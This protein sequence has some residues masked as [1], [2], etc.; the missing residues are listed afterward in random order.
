MLSA[1]SNNKKILLAFSLV[2]G[3]LSM[4]GCKKGP[5]HV[6]ASITQPVI[7]AG[8]NNCEVNTAGRV[9][10]WSDNDNGAQ[11]RK[12]GQGTM[13]IIHSVDQSVAKPMTNAIAVDIATQRGC[14]LRSIASSNTR[15][16]E[17]WNTN[18]TPPYVAQPITDW[19]RA[20]NSNAAVN[21]IAV[22]DSQDCALLKNGKV[23]CR[24]N[25]NPMNTPVSVYDSNYEEITT[26]V[27][28]SAGGSHTCALLK[29]GTV[30]CWGANN[31]GQL[32]DG[33]QNASATAVAVQG[34]NTTA[35]AISAGKSYTCAILRDNTVNC[36][37]DNAKGQ[38]GDG[39]TTASNTPVEVN[40]IVANQPVSLNAKLISAG[41]E[42]TCAILQDN[43]VQ[44]WGANDKSQL[45]DTTI[46]DSLM[47]VAVVVDEIN[48][49]LRSISVGNKHSCALLNDNTV[50]CWGGDEPTP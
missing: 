31:L 45:G 5:V 24:A 14:A 18:G 20:L 47:P 30:M 41:S 21:Q 39:T 36:W 19:R 4:A 49:N 23:E 1:S 6:V 35:K 40:T 50:K 43:T 8:E 46:V 42:H 28:L 22:S 11:G 13:Q 37:G 26:V 33:T 25:S 38:L 3:F 2:L 29:N 34:L 48:K 7:S 27:A 17:C 44:C 15:V 32:G 12:V 9:L 16:V 10:C